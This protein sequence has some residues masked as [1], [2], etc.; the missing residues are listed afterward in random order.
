MR[1]LLVGAVLSLLPLIAAAEGTAGAVSFRN[2][3]QPIFNAQ[4]VF[5]HVTGAE[6]GG[7]NL[8]RRDSYAALMA[9]ST[10]A[11]KLARVTPGQPGQ[12]YLLH[13]LHG[14]QL[15]AG[16]SGNRMPMNDPPTP[17]AASQLDLFQRW[18][19]SGAPNN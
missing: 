11:P 10:E 7:L 19:E 17:L 9:A 12:S 4:C 18:I 2:D 16:G 5:C 14:T 1:R 15:A 13:K 8:G 3:L 6:N